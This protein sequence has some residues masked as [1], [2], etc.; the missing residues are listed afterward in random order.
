MAEEREKRLCPLPV[1][2]GKA[3]GEEYAGR[4]TLL[5]VQQ[6]FLRGEF[7][8]RNHKSELRER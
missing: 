5:Q 7:D 1:L 2:R 4:N 8:K 6:C 3:A